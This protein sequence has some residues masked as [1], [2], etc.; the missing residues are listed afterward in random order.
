MEVGTAGIQHHHHTVLEVVAGIL[1][2]WCLGSQESGW[3]S[4]EQ[5]RG[6]V[7]LRDTGVLLEERGTGLG[8][9]EVRCMGVPEGVSTDRH[10]ES[11]NKEEEPQ[12]I[13][14]VHIITK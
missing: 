2:Q 12:T 3:G 14:R 1:L 6:M 11:W 4:W 10:T 9:P 7:L 5:M 8:V 13:L